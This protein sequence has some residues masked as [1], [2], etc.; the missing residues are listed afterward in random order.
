MECDVAVDG[1]ESDDF[2]DVMRWMLLP[3]AVVVVHVD[4]GDGGVDDASED[5]VMK[6]RV[7]RWSC[8]KARPAK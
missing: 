4:D 5:S 8:P 3:T 2:D 7:T 1:G 6:D